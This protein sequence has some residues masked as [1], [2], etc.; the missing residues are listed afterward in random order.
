MADKPHLR[1]ADHTDLANDD[2]FA[3]LTKIMGFDPAQASRVRRRAEPAAPSAA[4]AEDGFD[5]M[6]FSIDLEKELMGDFADDGAD[7]PVS[8]AANWD[9]P[10]HYE[11]PVQDAYEPAAPVAADEP[12]FALADEVP[13]DAG[14]LD[15]VSANASTSHLDDLD[16]E[17]E[18]AFDLGSF[19]AQGSNEDLGSIDGP[20]SVE[21]RVSF[22]A[23]DDFERKEASFIPFAANDIPA[24]IDDVDASFDDLADIDFDP[25]ELTGLSAE[26]PAQAEMHD[27]GDHTS[28]LYA[29]DPIDFGPADADAHNLDSQF[30]TALADVDF[31]FDAVDDRAEHRDLAVA[32]QGDLDRELDLSLDEGFATAM[33]VEAPAE[34]AVAQSEMSLEDELNA[35]LGNSAPSRPAPVRA[36]AAPVYVPYT[37]PV[38][39]AAP[40]P[41]AFARD[42]S[43]PVAN[44]AVDA[45]A[46]AFSDDRLDDIA[47]KPLDFAA[48]YQDE[49]PVAQHV[50]PE[51]HLDF[52]DADFDAA[53]SQSASA[54]RGN[55]SGYAPAMASVEPEEPAQAAADAINPYAA[56]AA[57]SATLKPSRSFAE[58]AHE[59]VAARPEQNSAV[60]DFSP[61]YADEEPSQP[62]DAASDAYVPD[63]DTYDVP[64]HA[65]AL[66]DDL[67][68]PEFTFED[69]PTA[70]PAYD[71]IDAEYTSLLNGMNSADVPAP[72]QPAPAPQE[73]RIDLARGAADRD[74]PAMFAGVPYPA[75]SMP[76]AAAQARATDQSWNAPGN[77]A[78]DIYSDMRSTAPAGKTADPDLSD[79]EF[80][81]DPDLDEDISVPA[82]APIE[83]RKA[84]RRG[85][86]IAAVVGGVALLGGVGALALSLGGGTGIERPRARQGR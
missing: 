30:D 58:V 7:L 71:D 59:P 31:G 68:L 62:V 55:E 46:P 39:A 26:L 76:A 50:E 51:F 19:A 72:A 53:L 56:L 38:A 32:A 41:E 23:D 80:A 66:A 40:Q 70:A 1:L 28:E 9:R 75:P 47:P 45:R 36:E 73:E 54:D 3:E 78:D 49:T 86:M 13:A 60:Y 22:R 12:V 44:Y 18:Q 37:P 77:L 82:Y 25:E 67:D 43:D 48:D 4:A 15:D 24:P 27:I 65:V 57:L 8:A 10:D 74:G 21:D 34:I 17:L 35:L 64:E 63:I 79:M 20:T 2:P 42:V 84:P 33:P 81:Y 11:Q 14:W 16:A 52:D 83:Q 85:M 6:D 29:A 69:E 5:E 61:T